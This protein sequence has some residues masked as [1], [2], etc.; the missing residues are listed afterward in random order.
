MASLKDI[1][2]KAGVSVR[3]VSRA[4]RNEG[5][6]GQATRERIQV[7]A[8]ELGYR[9]NLAARALRTGRSQEV[10]VVAGSMDELHVEK[11]VAF[12][13]VMAEAGYSVVLLFNRPDDESGETLYRSIASRQTAGVAMF[14]SGRRLGA[15]LERLGGGD[16]TMVLMDVRHAMGADV[17]SVRI[18]RQQ[19]VYDAVMELYKSGRRRIAFVGSP[20]DSSRT[21]GYMRAMEEAGLEPVIIYAGGGEHEQY[22]AGRQAVA[23]VMALDARPDALQ[24][25]TDVMATGV[26]AGLHERGVKVP[27]EIAVVGFDNRR[28]STVCWPRLSTVAQPNDEVGA[29]AAELLLAQIRGEDLSEPVVTLPTRVVLREST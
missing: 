27:G 28:L 3:T 18:D 13:R 17:P 20:E 10:A 25:H 9:P 2:N 6:V 19:G 8:D 11:L 5:Y 26:L 29:A 23:K 4:L 24:C 21:D 1:A 15:L 22:E 7:V 14:E 12:E 16:L